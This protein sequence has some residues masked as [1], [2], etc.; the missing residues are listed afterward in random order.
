MLT[1]K[2]NPALFWLVYG[3]LSEEGKLGPKSD[4]IQIANE[5]LDKVETL[6]EIDVEITDRGLISLDGIEKLKNLK[7]LTIKGNHI[8]PI[9][10]IIQEDIVDDIYGIK[11]TI[12]GIENII[13]GIMENRGK[14]AEKAFMYNQ[15]MDL[16]ALKRCPSLE[17]FTITH[18]RHF[19]TIDFSKNKNLKQIV[20]MDCKPLTTIK[21]LDSLELNKKTDN[22]YF[23]FTE[24]N[25]IQEI[26][27]FDKLKEKIMSFPSSR[28]QVVLP[29]QYYC[30]LTN[31]YKDILSDE[32]FNRSKKFLWT[33]T[34]DEELSTQKANMLK[35]R[36]DNIMNSICSKKDTDLEVIAHAYKYVCDNYEYD[37]T[38]LRREMSTDNDIPTTYIMRSAYH[39][40][41]K[42]K[43]VCT[44]LARLFNFMLA[45]RGLDA[46]EVFCRHSNLPLDNRLVTITH[47]ISMVY[48]DG[49]PYYLDPT[50]DG[51]REHFKYFMLNKEE[52][53]KNGH[54]LDHNNDDVINSPSLQEFIA[55]SDLNLTSGKKNPIDINYDGTIDGEEEIVEPEMFES[56]YTKK[57]CIPPMM[58]K[59]Y[60][61]HNIHNPEPIVYTSPLYL[62]DKRVKPAT[63]P[64]ENKNT[65][66]DEEKNMDM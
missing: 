31:K 11:D 52:M 44:G 46:R 2:E 40:L 26:K 56:F 41:E 63:I 29:L 18:Q 32:A 9:T 13:N 23:N 39:V 6:G 28:A 58:D 57:A 43:G 48:L 47:A 25:N 20:I 1:R 19:D 33:E 36:V 10:N 24:C 16:S 37:M 5:D 54:I 38:G 53:E 62:E 66:L 14:K 4:S 42:G 59:K 60:S 45:S 35:S 30:H 21:G 8:D 27:G 17:S 61:R 55:N 64:T 15:L 12:D 3:T 34:L 51:D 22:V 50:W 65:G 49:K 7:A